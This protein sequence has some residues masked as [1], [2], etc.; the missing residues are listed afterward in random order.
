MKRALIVLGLLSALLVGAGAPSV[1]VRAHAAVPV[2]AVVAVAPL[3]NTT[4][5]R[6]ALFDKTRFLF[7]VGVAYFCIHHV[8]KNYRNGDYQS[9]A[10]GRVRHIAGAAIVL[11]IAYNRLQAAYK[12]A[13]NSNSATL[14]HLVSPLN[15]LIGR[16]NGTAASLRGD[17]YNDSNLQ[18]LNSAANGFSSLAGQ[19]GYS[20]KDI[21]T[22]LPAG[23]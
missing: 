18:G 3:V 17:K 16:V 14:Q 19:N 7:D 13:N 21:A 10:P 12:T 23:S 5:T 11:V 6:P 9:G 2:A 1:S 8:I 15:A 4:Q 22:P 20:I